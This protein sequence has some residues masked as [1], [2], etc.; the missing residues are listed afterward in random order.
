MPQEDTEKH[1]TQ[2]AELDDDEKG[3]GHHKVNL[4]DAVGERQTYYV[5]QSDE[6][7]ALNNR[8]KLKLDCI[9]VTLLA[10][11]FIVRLTNPFSRSRG[12]IGGPH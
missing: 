4:E 5:P 12:F 11:E 2:V 1:D 9:V 10:I 8:V 3:N 6:E 7:R